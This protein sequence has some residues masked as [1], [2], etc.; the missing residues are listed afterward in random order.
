MKALTDEYEMLGKIRDKPE[1]RKQRHQMSVRRQQIH[2]E[3]ARIKREKIGRTM[4]DRTRVEDIEREIRTRERAD[5]RYRKNLPELPSDD[6]PNAD[7][8]MEELNRA[9]DVAGTGVNK[10]AL[11]AE[12]LLDAERR[13][14]ERNQYELIK[15]M[16]EM[17]VDP[18]SPRSD[19]SARGSTPS[20]GDDA[21]GVGFPLG[22][23]I[24]HRR[25]Q[26]H[27]ERGPSF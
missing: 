24:G 18:G 22:L 14:A 9:V 21:A 12:V 20:R 2:D 7:D 25:V 13:I 23:P 8:A 1:Y 6:V 3:I 4:V 27:L 11:N 16:G 26:G 5:A 17:S 19:S 15:A 10:K